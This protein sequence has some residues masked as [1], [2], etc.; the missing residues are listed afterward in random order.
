MSDIIKLLRYNTGTDKK[1][2]VDFKDYFNAVIFNSTIVAY[3]GAAVADLVSVHKNRY[4]IDPQTHIFQHDTSTIKS[5][6][7]ETGEIKLKKSVSKYL[8]ELPEN[9]KKA[10]LERD[11]PVSAMDVLSNKNE[12]AERVFKFQTEYIDSFIEKKEYNK[13]LD[14]VG[15]GPKPRLLIAPYFMLKKEYSDETISQWCGINNELLDIFAAMNGNTYDI[16]AQLV[17]DKKVLLKTDLC[18]LIMKTYADSNCTYIFIWIDDFNSF[19]ANEKERIA[20]HNMLCTFRKIDKKP[21]MAYGGYE[22]ILLCHNEIKNR[23]YG[24][25][26]SVGYGETREIVPVG[27]GLPVNKYYFP[28]LHQRLKFSDAAVILQKKGYFSEDKN[29]QQRTEDYYNNICDCKEC[30]QVI[31]NDIN[32]FRRYDES[33]PFTLTKSGVKRHR[34]TTDAMLAA[35]KH[36]LWCKINEW[37][38]L[39]KEPLLETINKLLN[40]AETYDPAMKATLEAWSELYAK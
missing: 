26:Q 7:K 12:L 29:I 38:L 28:P 19:F 30:R 1:A 14:F 6:N 23:L 31:N 34:P 15:A 36:F 22:S 32:N 21:I 9:L 17:L 8:D 37:K 40:D 4:I 24:V 27:G 13:Y 10:L 5:K 2:F 20:F 3:S 11:H 18:D 39:N 25:A 33:T 35:A 16:A